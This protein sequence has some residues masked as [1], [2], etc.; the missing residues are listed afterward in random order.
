[1]ATISLF[2]I[3]VMMSHNATATEYIDFLL[4]PNTISS[5]RSDDYT[6]VIK[7]LH[8]QQNMCILVPD[9]RKMISKINNLILS[10]PFYT[11]FTYP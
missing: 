2:V 8:V 5:T 9:T 10:K 6:S 4:A 1:V 7:N 11:H 3:M